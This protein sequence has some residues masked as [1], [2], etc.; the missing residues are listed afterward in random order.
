VGVYTDQVFVRARA[1]QM[2]FKIYSDELG[3]AWQL[4][5]TRLDARPDGRR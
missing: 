1:R 4:G 3:V 2:G 5:D